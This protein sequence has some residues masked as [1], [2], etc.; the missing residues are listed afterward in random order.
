MTINIEFNKN[1]YN[2]I[3]YHRIRYAEKFL[4]DHNKK[5]ETILTIA[6]NSGFQS[7]TSFNN[8]FKKINGMTPSEYRKSHNHNKL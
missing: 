2:Y 5:D 3:N 6:Y 8:Y 1:F 4:K 7:K